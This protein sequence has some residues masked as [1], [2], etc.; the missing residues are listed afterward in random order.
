M[1]DG[2]LW[3][4]VVA[5]DDR[6]ADP[7]DC[8]HLYLHDLPTSHGGRLA[9]LGGGRIVV[10]GPVERL[11]RGVEHEGKGRAGVALLG[12]VDGKIGG[13]VDPQR[14]APARRSDRVEELARSGDARFLV[15]VGGG[16]ETPVRYPDAGKALDIDRAARTV[17]PHGSRWALRRLEPNILRD[18]ETALS[19][20]SGVFYAARMRPVSERSRDSGCRT[21]A[22]V[23]EAAVASWA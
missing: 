16:G 11:L 14:G 9:R 15:S 23:Q 18:R 4:A 8:V 22:T 13:L 21:D 12:D 3:G 20:P 17:R 19:R 5:E 6:R 1:V 10:D 2:A 7:R